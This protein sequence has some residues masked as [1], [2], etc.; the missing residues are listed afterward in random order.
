MKKIM[1]GAG[2]LLLALAVTIGAV[3]Q[4]KQSRSPAWSKVPRETAIWKMI[5]PINGCKKGTASKDHAQLA[6]DRVRFG[7]AVFAAPFVIAAAIVV[8]AG[9]NA[10]ASAVAEAAA[11]ARAE[12]RP[13]L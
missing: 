1:F 2:A 3:V 5:S 7:A 12:A 4:H 10:V 9:A 6:G 13:H 11:D 8:A